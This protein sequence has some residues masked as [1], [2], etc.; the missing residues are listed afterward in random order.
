ML[1]DSFIKLE[2]YVPELDDMGEIQSFIRSTTPVNI[3]EPPNLRTSLISSN[4]GRTYIQRNGDLTVASNNQLKSWTEELLEFSSNIARQAHVTLDH[5]KN[6][7]KKKNL[8]FDSDL[9]NHFLYTANN[10]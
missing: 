1:D 4:A 10:R 8:K 7:F 5:I 3:H 9:R 6:D 2:H